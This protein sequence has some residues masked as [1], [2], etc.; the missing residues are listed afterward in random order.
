MRSCVFSN[1]YSRMTTRIF[2]LFLVVLMLGTQSEA[3]EKFTTTT[4]LES[5]ANK[6]IVPGLAALAD[7]AAKLSTAIKEL[8]EAPDAKSLAKAQ[9]SWREF[10]LV[11]KRNQMLSRGPAGNSAFWASMFFEALPAAVENVIRSPKPID[12]N[13]IA[14]LGASAKG[15]YVIEYLLF[16]AAQGANGI[17]GKANGT[18]RSSGKLMLEGPTAERRRQYVR[19]LAL[20]LEQRLSTIA[21]G[22]QASEFPSKFANGGKD[23]VD[24]VANQIIDGIESGMIVPL[25]KY[26]TQMEAGRLRYDMIEGVNSGTSVSGLNASFEGV[27]R[28][29]HG[30]DGLSIHEYVKRVNPELAG[31]VDEQFKTT[32]A[33]LAKIRKPLQETI[34]NDRPAV[35]QLIVEA[36]KL[37]WLC[38]VDVGSALGI[39]IMFASSDGD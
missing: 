11:Y 32:A 14:A 2:F 38:K 23:S 8:E 26:T 22:V 13:F 12:A 24:L 39:T 5:M 29:Y 20:D 15:F 6:C 27:Y 36:K 18:E 31:F 9:E 16:D 34:V 35:E 28:Y 21:K 10:Q 4:M 1:R 7:E 25:T 3:A 30:G 33:A 19:R 37:E 17:I